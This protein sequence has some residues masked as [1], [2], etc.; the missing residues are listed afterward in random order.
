MKPRVKITHNPF[1]GEPRG[2]LAEPRAPRERVQALSLLERFGG[3]IDSAAA[4]PDEDDEG[5]G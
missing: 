3:R 2:E 5:D 1:T 4:I